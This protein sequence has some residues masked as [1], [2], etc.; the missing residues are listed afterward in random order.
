M[1]S[2]F[3]LLLQHLNQTAAEFASRIG[4]QR[5]SMSHVMSG[6][7]KPSIDFLEKI[8]NTFPDV[9]AGWLITGNGNWKVENGNSG[10][11]EDKTEAETIMSAAEMKS[12]AEPNASPE[13]FETDRHIMKPPAN[14]DDGPVDHV[15]IVYKNNSFRML[16]P[17]GTTV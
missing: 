8:L 17:S 15:I 6:R 7:N 10:I 5:S 11:N 13:S 12:A 2:R 16:N 14:P 4:V 9:N 1:V 3:K